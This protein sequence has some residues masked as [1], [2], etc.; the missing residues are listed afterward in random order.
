MAAGAAICG[1]GFAAANA[2]QQVRLLAAAPLLGTAL[3]WNESWPD[4]LDVADLV[5][6]TEL[7]KVKG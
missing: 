6:L 7:G 5:P 4:G 3:L 2:M 1:L